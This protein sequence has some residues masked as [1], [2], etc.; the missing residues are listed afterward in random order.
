MVIVVEI[1]P[2]LYS[3][4]LHFHY[5]HPVFIFGRAAMLDAEHSF[6]K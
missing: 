3:D 4:R 2:T 5:S 6:N 1:L